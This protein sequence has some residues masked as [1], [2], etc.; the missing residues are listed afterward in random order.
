VI[1]AAFDGENGFFVARDH[2][3]VFW[4]THAPVGVAFHNAAFDLAVVQML[5][6][7][8]D[9]YA[10]V[11]ADL[12]WDTW[13]LHRL[14]TLAT[15]GHTAGGDGEATLEACASRYLNI[16]VPKDE[17]DGAGN[18]IRTSY[19]RFLGGRPE[20]IP[21][22]YLEYLAKDVIATH[23]IFRELTRCID[24]VL[25]ASREVWGYVSD[26]WLQDCQRRWGPL[27]HHIQLRAAIVLREITRAGLHVDVRQ[28]DKL[29]TALRGERDL[30]AT[31]LREQGVL[32]KG[33]GSQKALQA[34]F[35]KL[36]AVHPE[37]SFPKTDKGLFATS[38]EALHDLATYVPFVEDLQKYRAVDKLLETFL[39]KL[40]RN[41][42]HPSFGVLTRSG[43]TSSFG[44]VNAQNLPRDDRIRNCFV[45]TDG[46]V[47]LDL[48]Y[49]TI[50]LAALAQACTKQFGWTS[51]MAARINAGDDLHR[52][53][54]GFVTRKPPE[55]VSDSERGR[56]KPINFGK[57]G[58][59]GTGALQTYA[60][61]TYGIEYTKEEIME[62]SER[63][64][65][66]FPEMR[67]FLADK[68]NTPLELARVLGLTLVDH[69][70]HT[71][72]NRMIC[73][74]ENDENGH[75]PNPILGMMC[76][77]VM[78]HDDP[79]TKAGRPYSAADLDYFWTRLGELATKMPEQFAKAIRDR[80]PS[81]RLQRFV[82]SYVGR[83]GV[84]VLT[85]RLRAAAGYTA[86]H[87]TIF[88][89]LTSDGAKLG[90]WQVWRAG[91]R[92]ANF[93]HDQILVEVPEADDLKHHAEEIKGLMVD[94][95]KEVLPEMRVEVQYAATD[96][97]RKGAKPVFDK[98]GRLSLWYP[99]A[100]CGLDPAPQPTNGKIKRRAKAKSVTLPNTKG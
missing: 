37:V 47:F 66:L 17:V 94:G 54:A 63:W 100:D 22:V 21:S 28:R 31:R 60:K 12:V 26:D 40:V 13:L 25:T 52:V 8:L 85:G 32:A 23:R 77:K 90:L 76:L 49:S 19:G 70:E 55:K 20:N 15:E 45:P 75:L 97:W 72:D 58:G 14:Y 65:D 95:M 71:E 44:E 38:A 7:G 62:L 4:T 41:V 92:I 91:F 27:T 50:E 53:F 51:E 67:D 89:G 46:H 82:A 16:P 5:K 59:M 24:E 48:D 69:N 73:H 87:N 10:K 57:P 80:Q 99:Q 98:S 43:R 78:G 68:V 42:I 36:A 9:V 86:C 3:A 34:K 56:V 74:L 93:I 33:E 64:L 96:R 18:Q 83:A 61:M 79:R 35:R 39:S 1:G 30:L 6:P 88:Q 81:I 2:A 11:E 84:F 29:I